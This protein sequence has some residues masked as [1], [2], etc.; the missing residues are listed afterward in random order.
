[1]PIK[2]TKREQ[3]LRSVLLRLIDRQIMVESEVRV[4]RAALHAKGLLTDAEF[5]E[6]QQAAQRHEQALR[7]LAGSTEAEVLEEL[8]RRFQGTKQ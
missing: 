1:M 5:I 7:A 4:L 2:I 8:L 6:A 3:A